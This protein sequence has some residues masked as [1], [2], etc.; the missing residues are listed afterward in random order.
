[1]PTPRV[2]VCALSSARSSAGRSCAGRSRGGGGCTTSGGR[3][4]GGGGSG[5]GGPAYRPAFGSP[6]GS[7]PPPGGARQCSSSWPSARLVTVRPYQRGTRVRCV[8]VNSGG[9]GSREDGDR[10]VEPVEDDGHAWPER[11]G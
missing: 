1:M 4:P 6:G 8:N 10:T 9:A 2:S 3:Q 5:G 11:T 7:P